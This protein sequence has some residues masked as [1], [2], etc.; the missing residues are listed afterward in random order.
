MKILI[1][2]GAGYVGVVLTEELLKRGYKV[3]IFDNFMYGYESILHLV[4][5]PDLHVV[6]KDIRN[7]NE[8]DLKG[9][10]I[11]FH[12][13]AVSGYPACES[14]PHSAQVINVNATKRLVKGL[15]S[16]QLVIYAST[17]SFYGKGGGDCDETSYIK[18]VSLYGKTKYEA[19]KIV[20]DRK[21]SISLRFATIFGVSP[22]MRN[23]LLVNDFTYK[24]V[25]D[26]SVVIFDG[27]SKRTF[28]HISDAV[29]GYLLSLNKCGKMAGKVYNV[30]D[31]RLNLTKFEI[32]QHIKKLVHFE[33]INSSL[34]DL[35]VRN[36]NVS[37]KRLQALGFSI[38]YTLDDGIKSLVKLYRFY[39]QYSPYR[40][41]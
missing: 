3:T 24:A 37:F 40:I 2:G 35:D 26:R 4:E 1:T 41:I 29:D 21:N 18:P 28:L 19:E 12:L 8:H 22:K 36:F 39:K 38:N 32:A 14:N 7:V 34:G 25:N 15:K 33:I 9:F 23:D 13:A 17:T 6:K 16:S 5:N 10:D 31:N 20:M 11:V 27:H 30:G